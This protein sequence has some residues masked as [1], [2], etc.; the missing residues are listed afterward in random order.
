[1]DLAP[2]KTTFAVLQLLLLLLGTVNAAEAF[3]KAHPPVPHHPIHHHTTPPSHSPAPA[4]APSHHHGHHHH[5]PPPSH[6]PSSYSNRKPVAV[7]G[8]VYCK[9]CKY[10]GSETLTD[11]KTILGA[12]VKLECNNTKHVKTVEGETDKN[13]YFFIEGPKTVTTYGVHKCKVFLV[14]SPL[15]LCNKKTNLNDGVSGATLVYEKTKVSLSYALYKVGP[16]A[17]EPPK[18]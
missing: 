5:T 14:S 9:S 3:F 16:F 18:C 7:E 13:G 11:A 2:M 17:F 10:S 15:A 12:V 1:M 8:V 4:P 6:A